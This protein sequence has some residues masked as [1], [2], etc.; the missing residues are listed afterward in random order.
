MSNLA[1]DNGFD[2]AKDTVKCTVYITDMDHFRLVN[3]VYKLAF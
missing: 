1:E 3:D 2:L